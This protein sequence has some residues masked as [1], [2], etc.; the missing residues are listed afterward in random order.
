[1]RLFAQ[2]HP[3]EFPGEELAFKLGPLAR[4]CPSHPCAILPLPQ[5]VPG[6][7]PQGHCLLKYILHI[8]QAREAE[9]RVVRR[10]AHQNS[11]SCRSD[12]KAICKC[13]TVNR[14][15]MNMEAT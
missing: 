11:I 6:K 7:T 1:M 9:L 5:G 10:L 13:Y 3:V 8:P 2:E 14:A 4:E 15:A 12:F